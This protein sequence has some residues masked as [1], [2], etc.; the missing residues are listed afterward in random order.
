MN[1]CEC[2]IAK[3]KPRNQKPEEKPLYCALEITERNKVTN[4][5]IYKIYNFVSVQTV[6]RAF[7]CDETTEHSNLFN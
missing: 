3:K 2:D 6:K 1:F 7:S 4:K 5:L